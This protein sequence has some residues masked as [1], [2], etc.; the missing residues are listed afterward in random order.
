MRVC[1]ASRSWDVLRRIGRP[2]IPAARRAAGVAL[3]ACQALAAAHADAALTPVEQRIATAVREGN[4]AALALLQEIVNIN[5]GTMNLPGVR[6]VG[7][8]LGRELEGLGFRVRWIDG[9][10][11]GR[12]GHLVAERDGS[13]ARLLLIGHLDTVFEAD[14]PFQAFI[15]TSPTEARG[16][17]IIDMKGG[18]VIIVAALRALHAAGALEGRSITVVMTG[19]E[20]DTGE[21][22]ELARQAL[23]EAADRADVALGFEDGSGDPRRAVIARRGSTSWRL[24]V[25]APAAHSS[26]IFRDEIGAGAIF[27]AARV[28]QRFEAELSHDP[29]LT[30]NPGVIVGGTEATVD[31][32]QSRG[33]A[34]GKTNVVA[35]KAEVLGDLRAISPEQL[36]TAKGAME[37]VARDVGGRATA[38]LTFH[39]SYPPLA[40]TEGNRRLLALYDL[41]SRDAGAGPVEA[42]DPRAAG[43][44]DVSFTAGRVK[45]V[46][47]GI[48]LMGRD[49]HTERETADL[50]TLATQ[51]LRAAILIHRLRQ[52]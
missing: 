6:R 27:A 25:T 45:M 22:L 10:S 33:T 40:P 52:P 18:D 44:A 21:P 39:D 5:S 41:A 49:D 31:A 50:A 1:L 14:S 35:A 46:I 20:E 16:P 36:A 7:D 38:S 13:G 15:R 4:D 24:S 32:E 23:R 8:R 17:G 12:A 42:T 19:D 29:L 11:F 26:Q 47:D 37:R 28:L 3:L 9:A 43:A 34:F 51:T 30:F 2:A 48:G